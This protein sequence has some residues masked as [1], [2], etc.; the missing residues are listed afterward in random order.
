MATKKTAELKE[1]KEAPAVKAGGGGGGA[2]F[3]IDRIIVKG[4]SCIASI[5]IDTNIGT[6]SG[7]VDMDGE[8]CPFSASFF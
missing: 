2:S 5:E 6:I 1:V 3:P 8:V 7:Y 4:K